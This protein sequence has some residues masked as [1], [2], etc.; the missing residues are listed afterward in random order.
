MSDMDKSAPVP[1]Q[2][3]RTNQAASNTTL[4]EMLILLMVAT[5]KVT[6]QEKN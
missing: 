3:R 6:I 5:A 2:G 4:I 1:C